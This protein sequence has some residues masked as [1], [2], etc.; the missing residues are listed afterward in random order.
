MATSGMNS[1]QENKSRTPAF[2][3]QTSTRALALVGIAVLIGLL[4]VIIVNADNNKNESSASNRTNTTAPTT[5]AQTKQTSETTKQSSTTKPVTD[6]KETSQ[7]S[8]LVLNGSSIAGI[9]G[10]IT[11]E[12]N[13]LGYKTLTAGN[14][15][16]KQNGTTVYYKSGFENDAKQLATNVLPGILK[17]LGISQTVTTK[18]FPSSAPTD[19]DQQ[20]LVAANVVVNVGNP[21]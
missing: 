20:N 21:T 6:T 15:T 4:L 14:D 8:V 10:S 12:L 7:V 18:A 13:K 19:W 11:S 9:A 17:Q 5:T 3:S 16:S 1:G 2:K